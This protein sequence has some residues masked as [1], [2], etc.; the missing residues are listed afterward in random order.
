M[1]ADLGDGRAIST[2][3][4]E[5]MSKSESTRPRNLLIARIWGDWDPLRSAHRLLL[6]P[7]RPEMG[8]SSSV[9]LFS[10]C[11]VSSSSRSVSDARSTGRQV[12]WKSSSLSFMID[13]ASLWL[14]EDGNVKHRPMVS[15]SSMLSTLLR[16]CTHP[17]AVRI[18]TTHSCIASL[19]G[20]AVALRVAGIFIRSTMCRQRIRRKFHWCDAKRRSNSSHRRNA[21]FI[22]LP[23]LEKMSEAL[24]T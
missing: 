1:G 3:E 8:D 17:F 7:G 23:I 2:S 12:A 10:G 18:W 19:I 20:S 6:S 22:V 15:S 9:G 24:Q 16:G 21:P 11:C 13:S 5:S 14:Q 4:S